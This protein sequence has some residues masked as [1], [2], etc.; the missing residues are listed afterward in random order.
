MRRLQFLRKQSIY[1]AIEAEN[2]RDREG[3]ALPLRPAVIEEISPEDR[4]DPID[5]ARA[6]NAALRGAVA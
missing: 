1:R 3:R 2:A 4:R 6:A 5:I